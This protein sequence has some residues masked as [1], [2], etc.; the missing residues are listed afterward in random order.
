MET[1]RR[2]PALVVLE[3]FPVPVLAIA[4][5]G[6]ILFANTAFA[7]MVGHRGE[8]VLTMRFQDIFQTAPEDES[9]IDV[10]RA[11][12]DLVVELR[13]SEGSPVR[14]RMSK[15]ALLR[16]DDQV[17]LAVFHDLTEQ[18]WVEEL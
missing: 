9:V 11:H 1:L 7:E 14:A 8:Q 13:H 15:S 10:V 17:A 4:A 5:D 18:L 3:R 6:A 16:D 2:L 12:G